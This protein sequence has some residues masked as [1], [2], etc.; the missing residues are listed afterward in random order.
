M[1]IKGLLILISCVIV[2]F[3]STVPVSAETCNRI[4]AFVNNDVITLHELEKSIE[5]LTGQSS[6]YLK[7]QDEQQFL[8]IR[9]EI[10][11]QMINEK[12][13]QEKILDLGIQM[14]EAEIDSTVENIKQANQLTQ[15]DLINYLK[16]EGL[17]Y[18]RFRKKIKEDLER[19]RLVDYEVNSKTIVREDQ[20]TDYYNSHIDDY[21]T[22]AQVHIAGIS[23]IQNNPEDA[24]ELNELTRKAESILARIREGEDFDTLAEEFSQG[25]GAED[26]GNLGVLKVSEIDPALWKILKKLPQGGVSEPIIRG[27]SIHIVKLI[28]K[29]DAGA[30]PLEEVRDSIYEKLYSEEIEKRYASWIKDLRENSYIKIIF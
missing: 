25:P 26:G 19:G 7:A 29:D 6:D 3:D 18:E 17:S 28:K 15:E 10:L 12:I 23:L 14:T 16:A 20:I 4:V 1:R 2:F 9:R 24:E 22:D 30:R 27:N 13:A 11:E 8:V 5:E 21:K